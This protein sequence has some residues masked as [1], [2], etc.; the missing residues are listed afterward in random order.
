MR[1]FG[2]NHD[3][4]FTAPDLPEVLYPEGFHGMEITVDGKTVADLIEERLAGRI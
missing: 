4:T 2:V 3:I 1:H